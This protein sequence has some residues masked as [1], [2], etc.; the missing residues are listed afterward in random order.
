MAAVN[1]EHEA[2]IEAA[3]VVLLATIELTEESTDDTPV[4]PTITFRTFHGDDDPGEEDEDLAYPVCEIS[5]HG[6]R[7]MHPHSELIRT[8]DVDVLC[9]THHISDRK[10]AVLNEMAAMVRDEL[11]DQLRQSQKMEA[12]GRLAGGIA[13]DFNNLLTVIGGYGQLLQQRKVGEAERTTALERML[14]LRGDGAV[15][16][17]QEA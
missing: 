5:C 16:K 13:H 14:A 7:R 17:R 4:V 2:A 10:H 3:L 9:A 12:V 11:E 1:I 8:A 6:C 15:G